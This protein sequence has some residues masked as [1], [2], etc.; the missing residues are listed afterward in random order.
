METT[1]EKLARL[2]IALDKA[3]NEL[4]EA[5][6]E[7]TDRQTTIKAFEQEYEARI[8][9]LVDRLAVLEQAVNHYLE[10]IQ[11]MRNKRTFGFEYQSVD[12]QFRRAWEPSNAPPPPPPPPPPPSPATEAEIKKLYRQLARRFHPDLAADEADRIFRTEKMTAINDAYAARSLTELQA[13]AQDMGQPHTSPL[14]AG[15][16]EAEM[17]AV[18]EKEITRCQRRVREIDLELQN[19]HNH[20]SVAFSLEVKLAKR[21]GRDLWVETITEVER[22]IGRKTAELDMLRSQF[23]SLSK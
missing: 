1:Q 18:L 9:V 14:P 21:R 22:K 6:A 7:L 2:R 13:L 17:V 15:Q 4:V 16:T 10:R 11:A 8:G 3:K 19:L 23:A 12:E 20:P 5:E